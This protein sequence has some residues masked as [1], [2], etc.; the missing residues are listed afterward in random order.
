MGILPM[1]NEVFFSNTFIGLPQKQFVFLRQANQTFDYSMRQ[2]VVFWKGYGLFLNNRIGD[3]LGNSED[4]TAPAL[5]VL[6]RLS[7]R[8]A[9]SL[10]SPIRCRQHAIEEQAYVWRCWKTLHHRTVDNKDFLVSVRKG[11]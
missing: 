11:I 3:D 1:C 4:L 9:I 7:R 8:S 5:V 2:A 6:A 10:S